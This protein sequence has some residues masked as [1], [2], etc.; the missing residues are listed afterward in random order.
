MIKLGE[1]M[2]T[3]TNTYNPSWRDLHDPNVPSQQ[4]QE[5]TP[6]EIMFDLLILTAILS[7]TV[8][9]H[10]SDSRTPNIPA[11][12]QTMLQWITKVYILPQ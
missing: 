3:P 7:N 10:P 5:M 12:L 1:W 9:I 8:A 11:P 2:V 6:V 4:T